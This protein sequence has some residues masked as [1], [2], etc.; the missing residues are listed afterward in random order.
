MT[1]PL[2]EGVQKGNCKSDNFSHWFFWNNSDNFFNLSPFQRSTDYPTN[3]K[4][5]SFNGY[6]SLAN[7]S[8][9]QFKSFVH[10]ALSKAFHTQLNYYSKALRIVLDQLF[11]IIIECCITKQHLLLKNNLWH[12]S[13]KETLTYI[14]RFRMNPK[15]SKS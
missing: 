3:I 2:T 14:E 10:S 6:V 1:S 9:N 11:P 7:Y 15:K 5:L 12:K 8:A 13:N 4:L